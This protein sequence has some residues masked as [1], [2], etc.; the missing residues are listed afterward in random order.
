MKKIFGSFGKPIQCI[1]IDVLRTLKTLEGQENL[2]TTMH[3]KAR[4][5]LKVLMRYETVLTA[6]IFEVTTPLSKYL[7]MNGIDILSAH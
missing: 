4:A 2:K 7:Q 5:L 3:V 1:Y 6:Q